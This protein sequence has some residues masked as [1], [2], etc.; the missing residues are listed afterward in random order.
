MSQARADHIK[1]LKPGK[2]PIPMREW[3]Q[4]PGKLD[5]DGNLIY[6]TEQAHKNQCD[7]NRIIEK[8]DKNGIITHVSKFE[9][10]FGDFTGIEFQT[11]QQ[12]VALAQNMFNELPPDIRAEFENNPRNLLTFMENPDNREKAIK[13][14]L[15]SERWTPETDGLGEHVKEGQNELIKPKDPAVETTPE[16]VEQ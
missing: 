6:R 13:M 7:V 15:I 8:F 9:G 2:D 12:Q 16:S 5:G 11:M 10:K 4:R 14:G 1:N 3:C